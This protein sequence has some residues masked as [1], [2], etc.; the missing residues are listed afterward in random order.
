MK[1]DISLHQKKKPTKGRQY[2]N[3]QNQHYA[4]CKLICNGDIPSWVLHTAIESTKVSLFL[5]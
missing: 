5:S 4:L 2:K 1:T 3:D